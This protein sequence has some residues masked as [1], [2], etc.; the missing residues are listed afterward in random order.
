MLPDLE[1]NIYVDLARARGALPTLASRSPPPTAF[2]FSS[3]VAAAPGGVFWRQVPT[4]PP[5][6]S[7]ELPGMSEEEEEGKGEGKGGR[8]GGRARRK[9]GEGKRKAVPAGPDGCGAPGWPEPEKLHQFS[10]PSSRGGATQTPRRR[11]RIPPGQR[12]HPAGGDAGPTS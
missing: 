2:T 6:G 12:S 11:A 1:R 8:G 5:L 3:S 7:A 4:F 10:R 9:E